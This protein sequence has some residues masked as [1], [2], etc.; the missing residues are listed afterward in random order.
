MHALLDKE[1]AEVAQRRGRRG[2]RGRSS[3]T[4]RRIAF[5]IEQG[6]SPELGARPLKRAVERHLLAPLARAIVRAE[7]FPKGEQFLFVTRARRTR[8]RSRSSTPTPTMQSPKMAAPRRDRQRRPLAD[9]PDVRSLVVHPRA[10]PAEIGPS[11]AAVLERS[12]RRSRVDAVRGRKER[13]LDAINQPGFWE[14]DDRYGA[15]AEAEY[16]DRLDTA[17]RTAVKLAGRLGQAGP[18]RGAEL[19]KLLASR[20]LRARERRRRAG[21]RG[22][23][24]GIRPSAAVDRIR[25]RGGPVHAGSWCEM[26]VG[27]G[28]RRGMKVT[29]LPSSEDSARARRRRARAP[30]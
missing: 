29:E 23:P 3:S 9:V 8:S 4:S 18:G 27:W 5:L 24:R 15:I 25:L 1:L 10:P 6:F 17:L 20:A 26:Y 13:A 16:L 21:D 12:S 19:T 7:T 2:R 22:A 30:A 28:E 14:D 11:A